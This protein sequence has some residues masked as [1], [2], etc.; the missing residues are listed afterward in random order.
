MHIQD[1]PPG[2]SSVRRRASILL[3]SLEG[4]GAERTTFLIATGLL[5]AF[6]LLLPAE[7]QYNAPLLVLAVLGGWRVLSRRTRIGAPENRFLGIAFL[8]MWLPML[9]SLPDAV[10]LDEALRKTAS[11]GIYYFAGLYAIAAYSRA[12]FRDL[13]RLM[14]CVAAVCALWCLDAFWQFAFGRDWFGIPFREGDQLRSPSDV[15]GRL[16]GPFNV[17]GRL[18]IVLV[19]FSPLVFEA[20]RRAARHWP[21]SPV[22]L[23]P[24]FA[25]IL[26]TGSRASWLALA[27]AGA[28]YLLF[29]L[30]WPEGPRWNA[31]RTLAAAGAVVLAVVLAAYAWPDRVKSA[32][33]TVEPRI[34]HLAGLWSGDR[35]QF[36]LAT[37]CR[38]TLWRAG[39]NTW[40]EHWLNG[41][42]PRGFRHVYDE[43]RPE[44]DYFRELCAHTGA[45][46]SP[47]LLVL[48]I[49]AETG[50][51]GLLGYLIL[52]AVLL[53]RLG[54]LDR[55][56][57]RSAYPYALVSVVALFPVTGHLGFYALFPTSL[58]WWVLIVNASAFAIAARKDRE[59][60]PG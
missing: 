26:L 6:V 30:R 53:A 55:G 17:A 7:P 56:A 31:R 38:L 37:T 2:E 60:A 54:A 22:L 18:G 16:R 4:G 23:L 59:G 35:E 24:F 28:G 33:E 20:V 10:D 8:C 40:S 27:V 14:V 50:M 29:L 42:G 48:E 12:R 41:V 11:L 25:T 58:I 57:L 19:V 39:V 47:H 34:E 15:A 1:P 43:F 52:G 9:A 5:L 13:D 45:P 44:R 32:R 36:E 3:P 21:W 46:A 51:I 49:A